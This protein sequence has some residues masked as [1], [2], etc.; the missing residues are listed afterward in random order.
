MR[1]AILRVTIGLITALILAVASDKAHAIPAFARKYQT[2]CITCH[3][4]FPRLTAHGEAFRLNGF[5]MP[6]G[7]EL[8]TKDHPVS[9]GA[10]AYK[11][12]FPEAIWPSDIPGMPPLA[13][14]LVT[15]YSFN[16]G[17]GV[18]APHSTFA[19]DEATLLAA[20]SLGN[21]MSFFVGVEHHDPAL[22]ATL[23]EDKTIST[24]LDSGVGFFGWLMWSNLFENAVGEHHLNVRFGTIGKQ[25]LG[26][27]N[28]RGEN[29]VTAEDYLYVDA[30]ETDQGGPGSVGLEINGFGKAWR[31]NVGVLNGDGDNNSKN[32]FAAASI[33]IGGQGY[34]G[35]GAPVEDMD[36]VMLPTGFWRDDSLRVGVFVFR[37]Y[38]GPEASTFD[39]YGLDARWN[40]KDLALGAG[41]LRGDN[42]EASEK[43]NTWFAE[44]EYF[45]YPWLLPYVRFEQVT[46]DAGDA[47]QGRVVVGSVL[48]AR[49]NVKFNLEGT[50][51]TKN[52]PAVAAAES[53]SSAN[54]LLATLDFAF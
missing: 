5:R 28:S 8:T 20:G 47:G 32:F 43:K 16:T 11:K 44:A 36:H 14:R 2:A 39:R 21:S 22:D 4:M 3:A 29:K 40:W 13:L 10:D 54:H 31:Y 19:I 53:K 41:Y 46:S 34:D 7:D 50:F 6:E 1:T 48:L 38:L 30:L 25:D 33:K 52:E 37:S 26:L 51:Y 12:V 49:A 23:E 45:V 24:N 27:P 42:K 35:S 17:K 18:A 9:L 15:S